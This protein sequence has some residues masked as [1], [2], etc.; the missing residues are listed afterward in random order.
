MGKEVIAHV[1]EYEISPRLLN[2]FLFWVL[3][4]FASKILVVSNFLAKNPSLGGRECKVIYNSVKK[5]LEQSD[6]FAVQVKKEFRVLM[7]ASLRPYKGIFEFIELAKMLPE[8]KFDLILSDSEE[9][10]TRW[11]NEQDPPANLRIL[12][13]QQDVVPFY[14]SASLV[15]NLAHK[16]K[17]LETFGMT[18]LE[19]M[20][21]GLPAIVPSDGG[22]TEL[23]HEGVNGF[24]VD[25]NELA[26]IKTLIKRMQS[27]VNFWLDLSKNARMRAKLFTGE[28]FE[29]EIKQVLL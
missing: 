16:D 27:D 21:F 2:Q 4:S 26:R 15:V 17:W 20:Q 29:K 24:L 18:I 9:E 8:A 19:G 12:P 25:Y 14:S 22:V 1:H 11:E 6:T 7:L 28:I 10:V 13:V 23:V 3:R 5:E